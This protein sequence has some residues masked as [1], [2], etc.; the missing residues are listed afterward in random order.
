MNAKILMVCLGNICRSPVAEG[1]M[2]DLIQ[3]HNLPIEVDSAA[4]AP[5][6]IGEPPDSRSVAN[7]QKNGI[8]ISFLRARLFSVQDFEIFDRIYIMDDSNLKLISN[9]AQKE[10]HLSK[11]NFL[12]DVVYPNQRM[13]VP[14]PYYL[15]EEAFQKVYDLALLACKKIIEPYLT[16]R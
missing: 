8:D 15:N 13:P 4:L 16:V 12:M 10:E 14:D 2:I 9:I 6:H 1:I 5:Y 3:K 11:I 7:A